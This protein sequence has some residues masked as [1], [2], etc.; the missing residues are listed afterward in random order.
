M[1]GHRHVPGCLIGTA[2]VV[3]LALSASLGRITWTDTGYRVL[4]DRTVEVEFDVYRPEG[5]PSP[6]WSGP[7][8]MFGTV[9]TVAV[10]IPASPEPAVHRQ[11]TVRTTTRA[12][13]GV[14]RECTAD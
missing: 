5:Q 1:V 12:V 11:V 3:W 2:A 9:G 4:D 14:V 6:V 7:S 8:T 10:R 13:T